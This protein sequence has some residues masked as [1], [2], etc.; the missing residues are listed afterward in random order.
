[1]IYK[2]PWKSVA[3]DDGHAL[4]RGQRMAVCDKTYH[5]YT[6]PNGPYAGQVIGIEPYQRIALEDA[7]AFNCRKN[8]KR[9]PR[10]TKG[11][12][13]SKTELPDSSCCG[14][15]GCC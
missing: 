7:T 5:I 8:A 3:D 1:M 10:E 13:Y 9:H 12:N 14:P 4:Y 11:M 2:G 15:E 6:N